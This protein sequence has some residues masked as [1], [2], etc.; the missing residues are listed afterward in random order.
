MAA[1]QKLID[2]GRNALLAAKRAIPRAKTDIEIIL[3]LY[4]P[5]ATIFFAFIAP[6]LVVIAESSKADF[7]SLFSD[8]FYVDFSWRSVSRLIEI[9]VLPDTI[10]ITVNGFNFGVIGNTIVNAVIVTLAAAALGTTVALL[11]GLYRFPGR[12]IF[13]IIA[14]MPLL[15]APLVSTYIIKLYF[16]LGLH[17]N[18]FSYLASMITEPLIGKKISIAFAGQAG[19]ALAQILMFYPIVYINVLAALAAVDATLIEQAINLGARGFRLLR[20]IILPLIMPGILAGSTLV[21]ILSIEDVGG[22][23]IFNYPYFMSFQVYDNFRG[24]QSEAL[25]VTIAALSLLMLI[26]AAI[27]LVFVRRYLS[28]RYYAR[29]A[30]GAPRPFHGLPLGRKGLIFAYLVVLPVILLA[31]SPQIGVALLAF[32]KRW[33]GPTPELLPPDRLFVNFEVL[34]R[35]AGIVRSIENSVVY[36]SQAIVFI[37]ILGFMIGYAAARARLPGAGLLDIL[38]SLPLAVPGLVVAFSYYVFFI[39]YFRGT[40]LDPAIYTANVLVLAYVVRKIPFTVRAVFTSIIQ[41]PEELEEAARSLGARRA[42]VLQRIVIPL[43]WRGLLAGL[44]LSAIHVLSEVSVSITL[45]ALK[46]SLISANHTG[47]I[48]F[49]ILQLLTEAT[50]VEGGT[51]P[52]AKAAALAA[53]LMTLEAVVITVASRLTRRG[54][55]LVSV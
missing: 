4:I 21:Y 38:S 27:P 6:L 22:P 2:I 36:L 13:A 15:I 20:R 42:R 47:P 41:T 10:R 40:L 32:S 9:R 46:G 26:L 1:R 52:H 3:L 54:Q 39:T 49:A 8:K 25:R 14:Y 28:L 31:A 34:G 35:V 17:L 7:G 16:G 23:I 45:G 11:V 50:I 19:V 55:A 30:R 48:T 29:L 18:T 51:Q 43:V 37:A 33:I 24:I 5:L 44:L 12:R 53:I